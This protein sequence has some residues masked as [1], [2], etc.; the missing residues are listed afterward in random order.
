[1][2]NNSTLKSKI[3]NSNNEDVIDI[4]LYQKKIYNKSYN[5]ESD[6]NE[7]QITNDNVK[8][9]LCYNVVVG[10]QCH[11][12]KNCMFAHTLDDQKVDGV[13]KDA[14]DIIKNKFDLASVDLYNNKELYNELI[15]LSNI[16]P[17][18]IKKCCPGGYNCKYGVFSK[19]YQ[20]CLEDLNTGNCKRRYCSLVHLSMNGLVPF[21]TQERN[22]ENRSSNSRGS[23]KSADL[24][25][26][27]ES[28]WNKPSPFLFSDVVKRTQPD[29]FIKKNKSKMDLSGI[30]KKELEGI[31]LSDK[32]FKSHPDYSFDDSY[33]TDS[34]ETED[35]IKR[36]KEYIHSDLYDSDYENESIFI[37]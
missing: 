30:S 3:N 25:Q 22:H 17:K 15:Q 37:E 19:D 29:I 14:Y 35:E 2:K 8:R 33:S 9:M 36:A 5:I 34:F 24:K 4:D 32:Y 13:R 26:K 21:F 16:C 1:M 27:N 7:E 11:Y 10:K 12:K 18:C 28:V 31:T 6:N 20:V 23:N